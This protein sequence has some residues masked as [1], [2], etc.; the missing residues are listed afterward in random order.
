M[1]SAWVSQIFRAKAAKNGGI[2]RRRIVSVDKNASQAEL[3]DE[4]RRR[5]FHMVRSGNQLIILCN[6]GEFKVIC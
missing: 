2:V 1:A 6:K 5:G 3:R 4:V